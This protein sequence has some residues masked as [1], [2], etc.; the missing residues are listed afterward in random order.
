M[1]MLYAATDRYAEKVNPFFSGSRLR[2]FGVIDAI[3]A[4]VS[5]VV[6]NT[7]VVGLTIRPIAALFTDDKDREKQFFLDMR[8]DRNPQGLFAGEK[9]LLTLKGLSL[10][11]AEGP[12]DVMRAYVDAIK[13]ADNKTW[14]A[15][16]ADWK[17]RQT[18]DQDD[19]WKYVDRNWFTINDR[20]AAS[21]WDKSRQR[22]L[23][24]VHDVEVG[25]VS[26]PTIVY[27]A[28][29][30]P[31]D[32]SDPEDPKI[33]KEVQILMNHVG[34]FETGYRTFASSTLKRKWTLQRLDDGPWRIISAQGL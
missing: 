29:Q 27:D 8:P 19:T 9:N 17:V 20:Y 24:D 13:R 10:A 6:R 21:L 32:V 31:S 14:R 16:Y 12:D 34:L 25:S 15:C 18:F 22:V 28:A 5:D 23:T 1:Q 4:L 30:M 7:T 11:E 3:P 33:V 26:E 2:F